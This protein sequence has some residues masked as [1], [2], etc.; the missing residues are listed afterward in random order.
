MPRQPLST[1]L[2]KPFELEFFVMNS[3]FYRQDH[4]ASPFLFKRNHAKVSDSMV[5]VLSDQMTQLTSIET[6]TKGAL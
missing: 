6:I 5:E 2:G 4:L 3:F 1:I